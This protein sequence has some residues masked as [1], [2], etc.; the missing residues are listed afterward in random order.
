[1]MEPV[2]EDVSD[3]KLCSIIYAYIFRSEWIARECFQQAGRYAEGHSRM[4]FEWIS[5]SP[6]ASS[7][8]GWVLEEQVHVH[9]G[10]GETHTTT[11]LAPLRELEDIYT[12]H[13]PCKVYE[14]EKGGLDRQKQEALEKATTNTI[15]I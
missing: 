1:M 13:S 15:R 2:L 11:T 12:Q 5:Q 9:L 4:L 8:A 3:L 10:A 7:V 6:F 14:E